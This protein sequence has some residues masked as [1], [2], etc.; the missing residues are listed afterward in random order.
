MD[1]VWHER[2]APYHCWRIYPRDRAKGRAAEGRLNRLWEILHLKC[3]F[4]IIAAEIHAEP[5]PFPQP[6]LPYRLEMGLQVNK[7][8]RSTYYSR[9]DPKGYTDYPF[10]P[11]FLQDTT[12]TPEGTTETLARL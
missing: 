6:D 8:D 4:G 3:E 2:E 1:R 5:S 10:S 9:A 7:G 12:S 11:E